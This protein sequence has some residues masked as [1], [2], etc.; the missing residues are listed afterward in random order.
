MT[1]SAARDMIRTVLCKELTV[2][3]ADQ[4]VQALVPVEIA[5]GHPVLH[6]G[7]KPSGLFLLLKGS[8]E[9][10]KQRDGGARSLGKI[11]APTVLGEMSLLTERPHSATV[12]T[13][14]DCDFSLLTTP[15]FR[16]LIANESIAA[17][18]LLGTI[19]EVLAGR[20]ARLDQK[21]VELS[22]RKD[23]PPPVEE[24][25]AFKHKLFNEW[26]F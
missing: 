16:R 11:E 8:V 21:V 22:A 26:S 7:D 4:I 20:L 15:Q 6:E 13:V 19:A 18:K 12:V 9:I 17:Y 3:Q 5:A 1:A 23:G 25:A 2:E 10:L 24:L 14:T